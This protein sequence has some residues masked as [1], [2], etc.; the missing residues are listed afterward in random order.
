LVVGASSKPQDVVEWPGMINQILMTKAETIRS[1]QGPQGAEKNR[2]QIEPA[3][4]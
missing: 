2:R 1:L 4:V 3:A